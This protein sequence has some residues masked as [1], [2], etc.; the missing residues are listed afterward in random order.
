MIKPMS[1]IVSDGKSENNRRF[2]RPELDALRF[3]AFFA[4]FIYHMPRHAGRVGNAFIEAGVFGVDLFFVLS[5]YLITELLLKEKL[6]T[7]VLDV[8][9]FYIRRI[10]RI[11][12]LYFFYIALSLVPWFNPA[13]LL[14]WKHV[15]A[16][17]LLSGNWGIIA[18]G[19]PLHSI[20]VPLWTVSIE[21][22][23][24]LLWPPIVRGLERMK[25]G[26]AAIVMVGA[27][28]LMRAAMVYFQRG[29]NSVWCN[30]VA[31]L[32]PIALGIFL[33]FLLKG[34]IPKVP[35]WLRFAMTGAALCGLYYAANVWHIH[36]PERLEWAPTMIGFPL[37]AVSCGMILVA[38]MG[39][40][41]IPNWLRYLGKIS[42]GLYVYH[43]LGIFLSDKMIHGVVRLPVALGITIL[44]SV[45][46]YK[47][48]ET[49]F[50]RVKEKFSHV[51]SRP[52]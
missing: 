2:Y 36:E 24:Y 47:Y 28:T 20:A 37:V 11:W 23:F 31:R 48:L 26:I 46:S 39:I 29:Q 27:S 41:A 43:A 1:N 38:A 3:F 44:L 42:Y 4:V 12:P 21:E 16:F 25:I 13:H 40:P 50:L 32:D 45:V 14:T 5:A 7:G 18:W 52:V 30:T 6:L 33:A 8:K 19:W 22:Q 49:P 17:L 9:S 34:R 10:L 15:A 35:M 51:R